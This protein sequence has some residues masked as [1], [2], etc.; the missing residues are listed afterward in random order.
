MSTTG[1]ENW[2]LDLKNVAQIFPFE[3]SE[4]ILFIIG[5]VTWIGWHIWYA[6]WET[7]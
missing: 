5:L 3:G 1:I 2:A 7:N 6:K 4:G